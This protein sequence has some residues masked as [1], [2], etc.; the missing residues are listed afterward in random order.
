MTLIHEHYY[1]VE[2]DI[3]HIFYSF[4]EY[5][6]NY[7]QPDVSG[8]LDMFKYILGKIY[9]ESFINFNQKL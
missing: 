6:Y 3:D 9:I 5:I 1:D 7:M 8:N 4:G 2:Y